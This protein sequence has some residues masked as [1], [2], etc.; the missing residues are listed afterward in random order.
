MSDPLFE[1]EATKHIIALQARIDALDA[2]VCGL[3]IRAGSN[4]DKFYD[5]LKIVTETMKQ[6]RLEMLESK[7][8]RE[9]AD[10]SLPVDYSKI[11]QTL[12]D[13][14]LGDEKP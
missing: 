1:K 2:V 4:Y 14:I 6:K 5:G 9:A 8:P 10:L 3:A 13:N 7:L 11:D 12:L